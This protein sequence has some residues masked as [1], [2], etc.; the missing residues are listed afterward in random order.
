MATTHGT[1]MAF[2]HMHTSRLCEMKMSHNTPNKH[3]TKKH[4]WQNKQKVKN[5]KAE[6]KNKAKSRTKNEAKKRPTCDF[7]HA[8]QKKIHTT[9]PN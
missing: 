9:Q 3:P 1:P 6:P 8:P 4:D 7:A 2:G 5:T